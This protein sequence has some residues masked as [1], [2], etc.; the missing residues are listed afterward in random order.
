MST[1]NYASLS[2]RNL[3]D[4]LLQGN[5]KAWE[6]VLINLVAPLSR[7]SKYL[8]ICK[9]YN[10]SPDALVTATWQI[11]HKNDY[12]RLRLFRFESSFKTYLFLIVRE[13]QR[14]EVKQALGKTPL[15]LSEEEDISSLIAD[16]RHGDSPEV[17]DEIDF[18]NRI[19]AQLW[20]ENPKQAW[21]LLMRTCLGQPAKVVASFM[22]E[23]PSNVDQLNSRAK[24]KMKKLKGGE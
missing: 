10:I 11:L 23:T 20:R 15:E 4:L 13:A 3:V 18:A 24:D 19:F 22:N 9:K 7:Q 8:Q 2:D 1:S 14:N 16:K 6:Y 12:Q 5:Q 17:K 21:V